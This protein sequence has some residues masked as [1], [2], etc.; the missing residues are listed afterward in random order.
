MKAIKYLSALI[1]CVAL[2]GCSGDPVL[3]PLPEGIGLG[4]QEVPFTADQL[5]G[6][7]NPGTTAWVK[8]YIVGAYNYDLGSAVQTD[9]ANCANSNILI[10]SNPTETVFDNCVAVQLGA[11]P[12]RD[13]LNLVTNPGNLGV[14]VTVYGSLEKYCGLPGVKSTA[15]AII[16]GQLYGEI[17]EPAEPDA[18]YIKTTQLTSGTGYLLWTDNVCAQLVGQDK[19]YSWLYVVDAPAQSDGTVSSAESNAYVFTQHE[20]GWTIMSGT[21]YLYME[22]TYNS[23]QLSSTLNE[24]NNN[25]Y[26]TVTFQEDGRALITNVGNGKTIQ[27]S[28]AHTSYGAYPD[29]QGVYPYLYQAK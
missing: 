1:L 12:V 6:M 2:A 5:A 15:A 11:G 24:E 3:P 22:G 26:W 14:E 20:K 29:T 19:N 16:D 25:F 27:Y 4:T 8:G 10:A 17:P 23:F 18:G 21:L 7:N 28:S 9:P 13:A